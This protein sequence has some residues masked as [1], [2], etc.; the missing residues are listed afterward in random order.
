MGGGDK[1]LLRLGN[2]LLVERAIRRLAPQV[3][4]VAVN[5]N[6]NATDR[7][8]LNVPVI[9]DQW[10]ERRGPLAGVLA[11]MNWAEER[12][13]SHIVTVAGDTPFFPG[14]LVSE[15]I[16]T[17]RRANAA[18]VLAA[19]H[20]GKVLRRHP[21]FGIWACRLAP[22]LARSLED[23][24]RKIVAWSDRHSTEISPFKVDGVDPFFNVN[25]PDQ[26]RLARHFLLESGQ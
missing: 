26:L 6:S 14:N 16:S 7:P 20:D 5:S 11:G 12:G 15:L 8:A 24:Q 10:P 18:L 22:D 4:V 19:S 1:T 17:M 13:C 2:E 3:D 9:A 23:G 21:T 25:T